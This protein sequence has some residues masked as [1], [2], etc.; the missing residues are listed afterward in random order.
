MSLWDLRKEH[1][2]GAGGLD[3]FRFPMWEFQQLFPFIEENLQFG[4]I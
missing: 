1:S 3:C 4:S 2:N